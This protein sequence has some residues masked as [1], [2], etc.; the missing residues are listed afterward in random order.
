MWG[1]RQRCRE[2]VMMEN[3]NIEVLNMGRRRVDGRKDLKR[4]LENSRIVD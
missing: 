1:R 2:E 4:T 3:Y